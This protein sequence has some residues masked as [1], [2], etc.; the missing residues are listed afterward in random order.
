MNEDIKKLKLLFEESNGDIEYIKK[1]IKNLYDI[2]EIKNYEYLQALLDPKGHKDVKIPSNTPAPI[3]SKM[4]QLHIQKCITMTSLSSLVFKIV[5]FFLMSDAN[6][7]RDEQFKVVLGSGSIVTSDF[8]L[9]D[10]LPSCC[11]TWAQFSYYDADLRSY[12]FRQMIDDGIYNKYRLVSAMI[13]LKYTGPLDEAKGVIGGG[14]SFEK[15]D[16]VLCYGKS[17]PTAATYGRRTEYPVKYEQ[18]SASD[19]YM[20]VD[21]IRKMAFFRECSCLEGLKMYYFP[22]DNSY[23]EFYDILNFNDVKWDGT[24]LGYSYPRFK[25]NQT[26]YKSDF[27]WNLFIENVPISKNYFLIDIYLNYECLLTP[28]MYKYIPLYHEKKSES[29]EYDYFKDLMDP[30][31]RL[32]VRI[33][34][35]MPLPTATFQTKISTI[36]NVKNDGWCVLRIIPY[37]LM[38][39]GGEHIKMFQWQ[40]SGKINTDTVDLEYVFPSTDYI[41]RNNTT[42][43]TATFINQVI[44]DG[45]YDKYRLVSAMLELK[46]TG[47]LDQVQGIIGGGIS[48]EHLMDDVLCF[49]QYTDGRYR[50]TKFLSDSGANPTIYTPQEYTEWIR[51]MPYHREKNPLEGLKMYYFPIDNSY[52]EFIRVPNFDAIRWNGVYRGVCPVMVLDP[53]VYKPGFIWY[54]Y[55]GDSIPS[56]KNYTLEMYLNYELIPIEKMKKYIPVEYNKAKLSDQEKRKIIEEVQKNSIK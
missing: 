36:V 33:P 3:P 26:N 10:I 47:P 4:F 22:V 42:I 44:E 56:N 24:I 48:F 15:D 45:I 49:G 28:K 34:S 41:Y 53:E 19:N 39:N 6:Q 40:A 46:Y 25:L 5:P 29:M 51:Q 35:N 37:F 54:V 52:L 9:T 20:F 11:L 2:G 27:S 7:G 13:E 50:S 55:I 31:N 1:G 23:F 32:G 12:V 18:R 38:T 14:I 8:Y 43:D 30:K 16:Y 17:T 21:D